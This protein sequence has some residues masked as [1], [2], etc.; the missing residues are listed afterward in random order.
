MPRYINEATAANVHARFFDNRNELTAPA[1]V[2]YLIRDLTN[3]REVRS[4]TN[5]TPAEEIDI[6]LTAEDNELFDTNKKR[7]RFE[8]RVVTVQA[9]V[10]L[11][12]QFTEE[13]HYY[14]RNIEGIV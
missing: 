9:N 10:G 8:H 1:S 12:T 4:W 3:D 7:A 14:L 5:V 6:T 2:R 13:A 11:E